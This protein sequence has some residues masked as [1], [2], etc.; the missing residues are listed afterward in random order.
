MYKVDKLRKFFDCELCLKTLVDP[1]TIPC[2]SNV[3]KRHIDDVLEKITKDDNSKNDNFLQCVLCYKDHPITKEGFE[4]NKRLR[5]GLEIEFNT[6]KLTPIFDECKVE[7]QKA[8]QKVV[9]IEKLEKNSE[10][11]IYEYFEDIKRQVDIRREDMKT[12][13]DAYSNEI[14]H[15]IEDTQ[16]NYIKLSKEVDTITTSIETSKRELDDYIKRF[17]TLEI[18]EKKFEGIKNGVVGLNQKLNQ[19]IDNHNKLLIGNKEY[20]FKFHE[21]PI[22][23]IF[24]CFIDI[25][26]VKLVNIFLSFSSNIFLTFV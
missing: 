24:G 23:D 10:N 4:I 1:V 13:I 20:S 17:D 6:L 5:D 7:I 14:I 8:K 16:S 25:K 26:R 2:G 11:N 21:I 22:A 3:C 15:S 19:I 9:E 12:K 18:D